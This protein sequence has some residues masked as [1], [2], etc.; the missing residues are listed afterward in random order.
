[1]P[2]SDHWTVLTLLYLASF[3]FSLLTLF[4]SIVAV[5]LHSVT[6]PE[7]LL[8]EK[9]CL[10]AFFSS[11]VDSNGALDATARARHHQARLRRAAASFA[12]CSTRR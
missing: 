8:A 2:K 9:R 6:A 1:M 11:D 12:P 5:S 10:Q 7:G 4:T 3:G